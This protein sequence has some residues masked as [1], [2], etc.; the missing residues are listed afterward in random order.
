MAFKYAEAFIEMTYRDAGA[1]AGLAALDRQF[2]ATASRGNDLVAVVERL[3][4]QIGSLNGVSLGPLAD[5]LGGGMASGI[6]GGGL[7]GI[8]SLMESLAL[9]QLGAGVGLLASLAD[10]WRDVA[11]ASG[12][13]AAKAK[14]GTAA[15]RQSEANAIAAAKAYQTA[16]QSWRDWKENQTLGDGGPAH[17]NHP[18]TEADDPLDEQ[19]KAIGALAQRRADLLSGRANGNI[20]Q[21]AIDRLGGFPATEQQ[22]RAQVARERQRLLA[23]NQAQMDREQARRWELVDARKEERDRVKAEEEAAREMRNN[24]EPNDPE[25]IR[26]RLEQE[27]E[28]ADARTQARIRREENEAADIED[29]IMANDNGRM[30]PFNRATG[31]RAGSRMMGIEGLYNAIAQGANDPNAAEQKRLMQEQ[32]KATKEIDKHIQE[33]NGI[34]K[35]LPRGAI[36]S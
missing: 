5:I 4:Y 8:G 20:R 10:T 16:A 31:N 35:N 19:M 14:D 7:A 6:A 36:L 28:A 3:A 13:F 18:A 12:E 9:P 21:A 34:L 33:T 22:I 29:R 17:P 23:D 15:M 27:R 1:N 26:L 11:V 32:N 25:A 30:A 24:G 2:V